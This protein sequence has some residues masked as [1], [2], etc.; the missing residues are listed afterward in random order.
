ML[1]K[2]FGI[3]LI[4][5]GLTFFSFNF[6]LISSLLT[7]EVKSISDIC[8]NDLK[9]N[10]LENEGFIECMNDGE[11][12]NKSVQS[13]SLILNLVSFLSGIFFVYKGYKFLGQRKLK[14]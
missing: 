7:E 4:I 14:I 5:L 9:N 6:I 12:V 10:Y 1:R 8:N 11:R 13:I 3:L 2:I